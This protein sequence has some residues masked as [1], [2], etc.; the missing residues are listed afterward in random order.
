VPNIG[1]GYCRS[2]KNNG[3]SG[4]EFHPDSCSGNSDIRCCVKD[5]QKPPSTPPPPA[6]TP[7]PC[8]AA[9]FDKLMFQDSI[10]TFIAAKSAE[11]PSC[12]TWKDD[13]CSCSPDDLGEYDFLPSCKRHD[14][15]YRNSKDQGRFNAEMK[16]R[17]D[18]NFKDDLYDMCN[19]FSGWESFK[20]VECRRIADIYVAFVRKLGK[21]KRDDMSA[22]LQKREC[23]LKDA[24]FGG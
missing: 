22:V 16:E 6:P 2:V 10:S 13:G 23:D 24:I 5:A 8:T 21:K 15:G 3:C 19:K 12:F 20:G 11:S 9:A 17:I 18:S 1:S 14:F 7:N 4:G